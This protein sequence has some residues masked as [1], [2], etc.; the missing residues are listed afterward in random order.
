MQQSA[1]SDSAVLSRPSKGG[2]LFGKFRIVKVMMKKVS[3]NY[4][5]LLLHKESE[6]RRQGE[7]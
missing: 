6:V 1:A 3:H 5:F 2:L 4:D 7:S